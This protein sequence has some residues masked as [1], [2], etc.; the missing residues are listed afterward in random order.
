MN[1]LDERFIK[2][3]CMDETNS[4]TIIPNENH[5]YM[6]DNYKKHEIFGWT[7]STN[8]HLDDNWKYINCSN[9]TV[10]WLSV[11]MKVIPEQLWWILD[12]QNFHVQFHPKKRC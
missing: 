4:Q 2:L 7:W 11:W 8:E 10:G 12:S 3:K 6:N 9:E 5:M 1:C